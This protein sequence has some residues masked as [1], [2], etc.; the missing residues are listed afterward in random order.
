MI[1]GL[2]GR[3]SLTTRARHVAGQKQCNRADL[4]G[5][6]PPSAGPDVVC[7]QL[8]RRVL[9]EPPLY[10]FLDSNLGFGSLTSHTAYV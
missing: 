4:V 2:P 1:G 3:L 5:T 10:P 7:G 9:G 8:Q 6:E